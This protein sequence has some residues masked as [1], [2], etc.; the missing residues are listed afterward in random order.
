MFADSEDI[1]AFPHFGDKDNYFPTVSVQRSIDFNP[2]KMPETNRH[3]VF[4]EIML[5]Q[6]KLSITDDPIWGEERTTTFI[7]VRT[8]R[9]LLDKASTFKFDNTT[10]PRELIKVYSIMMGN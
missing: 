1:K 4:R 2:I 5:S 8:T 7:N 10:E 9:G 6:N 3:V